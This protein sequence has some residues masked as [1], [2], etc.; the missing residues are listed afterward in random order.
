MAEQAVSVDAT[1]APAALALAG[2]AALAV[3]IGI[4][5]FAFTP[6]LPMM[7]EDAGLSVGGA[8]WL[9]SANY[10]G[11]LI[12]ALWAAAQPAHA[13]VAI[14][15]GLVAIGIATLG[16]SLDVGMA[17]WAALR[18]VAG[19]A[20]AWVL[21]HVSAACLGRLAPLRR[22][23]LEGAVFSG[24]G[25]GIIA[26]GAL[27]AALI[28]VHASSASAWVHLGLLSLAAT[29]VIWNV[30]EPS[31]EAV[32]TIRR[33]RRWSV[34]HARFAFAYGAF[35]FGYIIP[36]TFI[37]VLAKDL[38]GDP[39]AFGWAWPAFGAAAAV[40]TLAMTF[41]A[42]RLS[43]RTLWVAAQLVMA[44]GV[45]AP[46]VW[47]GSMGIA[48]AALCVGGTFMVI[49]MAGMMEARRVATSDPAGLMAAMTAAFAI[50]QIVGPVLMS[51]LSDFSTA[52]L[53][54]CGVLVAGV[55]ALRGD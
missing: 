5:R 49:T 9:A 53:I 46:V 4:G 12:G 27:C 2:L 54:A 21:I 55:C 47:P 37:P 52:L 48:L 8:G 42:K 28:A 22:P 33:A 41:A 44:L 26:A 51:V 14:R 25:V 24:V 17:G 6:I 15:T 43:A 11:Y 18:F 36:A 39:V 23:L 13:A 34:A 29:L 35:G 40:S 7:R 31:F 19:I 50:G 32:R 20:S 30:F 45:S 10:A 3:A 16:M 38:I 1:R